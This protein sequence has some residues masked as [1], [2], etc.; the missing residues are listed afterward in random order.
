MKSLQEL[1]YATSLFTEIVV[2]SMLSRLIAPLK[3]VQSVVAGTLQKSRNTT[4]NF[5]NVA[6]PNSTKN[7]FYAPIRPN[8]NR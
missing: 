1:S 4:N 6:T 5:K 2:K 8:L 3:N 7:Y